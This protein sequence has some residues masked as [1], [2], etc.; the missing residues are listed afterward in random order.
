MHEAPRHASDRTDG[1][2][3]PHTQRALARLQASRQRLAAEWL[4]PAPAPAVGDGS[5]LLPRRARAW[6]RRTRHQLARL[7]AVGA[8]L[9]VLEGWW[10]PHP[11]R[12][13]GQEV[14]GHVLPA[15][16]D[17]VRRHPGLTLTLAAGMA[18]AV[19]T[20]RPWTHP[21][22]RRQMR[23]AP[24]R[25]GRFVVQQVSQLPLP[26][27]LAGLVAGTLANP[28]GR[29]HPSGPARPAAAAQRDARTPETAA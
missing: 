5:S 28:A 8:T 19:V 25:V 22:F 1:D 15:V 17:G 14:A 27:L 21:W 9:H 26:S 11:W 23:S 24:Q 6:W 4:P 13:A 20:L 16:R 12:A 29:A 3:R 2:P 10:H 18:A 7:P